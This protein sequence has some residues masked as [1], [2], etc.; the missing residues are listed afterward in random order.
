MVDEF[1]VGVGEAVRSCF[2]DR[3]QQNLPLLASQVRLGV[4]WMR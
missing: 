2:G 3:S 4:V 1:F